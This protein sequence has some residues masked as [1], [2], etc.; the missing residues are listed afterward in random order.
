M[1]IVDGGPKARTA[2]TKTCPWCGGRLVKVRQP[3]GWVLYACEAH[4]DHAIWGSHYVAPKWRAIWN[5]A[6]GL[7]ALDH[8]KSADATVHFRLAAEYGHEAAR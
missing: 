8:G 2:R 6:L 7:A 5:M 1:K 4:D 3:G